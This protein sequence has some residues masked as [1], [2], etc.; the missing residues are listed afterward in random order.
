MHCIRGFEGHPTLWKWSE[1]MIDFLLSVSVKGKHS[2]LYRVTQ[3]PVLPAVGH[4]WGLTV[5]LCTIVDID[6]HEDHAVPHI[7]LEINVTAAQF[8]LLRADGTWVENDALR[9]LTAEKKLAA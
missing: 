5:G 6:H 8:D 9:A 4:N 3:W 1:S 2:Y 7:T